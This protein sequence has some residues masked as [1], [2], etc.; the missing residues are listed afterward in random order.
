MSKEECPLCKTAD[1]M[2]EWN[3]HGMNH[4][5]CIGA[6]GAFEIHDS[7]KAV[8]DEEDYRDKLPLVKRAAARYSKEGR[9]LSIDSREAFFEIAA[10]QDGLERSPKP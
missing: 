2:C 5:Q 7:V 6:C 9:L 8:L 3:G 10:A 4:F 1:A